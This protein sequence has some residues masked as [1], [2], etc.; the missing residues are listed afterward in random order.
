M[1]CECSGRGTTCP[2]NLRIYGMSGILLMCGS[3]Y[4]KCVVDT[5]WMNCDVNKHMDNNDVVSYVNRWAIKSNLLHSYWRGVTSPGLFQI[6]TQ[7]PRAYYEIPGYIWVRIRKK[8]VEIIVLW[9]FCGFHRSV[10]VTNRVGKVS[11][12]LCSSCLH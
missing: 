11:I 1:P 3:S 8:G 10:W 5:A 6:T 2:V 12:W 4:L 9:A 7:L